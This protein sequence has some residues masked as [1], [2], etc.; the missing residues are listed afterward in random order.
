MPIKDLEMVCS[1]SKALLRVTI[2]PSAGAARFDRLPGLNVWF[3]P[4]KA[5]SRFL[6][7]SLFGVSGLGGA[8]AEI[9]RIRPGRYTFYA[10]ADSLA[11]EWA[12]PEVLKV[13]EPYGAEVDLRAGE[14]ADVEMVF[15]PSSL[16]LP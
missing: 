8:P 13:L 16:R 12:D 9:D 7:L 3:R 10:I 1:L 15:V 5:D 6:Y 14:T 2:K 4:D 11:I